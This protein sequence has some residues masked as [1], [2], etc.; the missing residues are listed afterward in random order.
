MMSIFSTDGSENSTNDQFLRL[1]RG[2]QLDDPGQRPALI[3]I[4]ACRR[5]GLQLGPQAQ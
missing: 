3:R 4:T 1:Q 5:A 2:D